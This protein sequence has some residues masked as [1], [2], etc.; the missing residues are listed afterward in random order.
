MVAPGLTFRMVFHS[1]FNVSRRHVSRRASKLPITSPVKS[2]R[3]LRLRSRC[4]KRH[5][6]D[7]SPPRSAAIARCAR[8]VRL[9]V[10]LVRRARV[11]PPG[12]FP[13]ISGLDSISTNARADSTPTRFSDTSRLVTLPFSFADR[14]ISA[15]PASDMRLLRKSTCSHTTPAASAHVAW[16]VSA[17]WGAWCPRS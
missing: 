6:F 1:R 9:S 10:R 17:P 8:C 5:S 14:I 15:V 2:P 11:L 7:S 16:R 4:V 12:P 3:S 13:A